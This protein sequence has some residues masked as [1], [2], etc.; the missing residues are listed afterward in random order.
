MIIFGLNRFTPRAA[1]NHSK[2]TPRFTTSF[3]S[4]R[5]DKK[6]ESWR[7]TFVK[8]H[9]PSIGNFSMQWEGG[10]VFF[11][12]SLFPLIF[13]NAPLRVFLFPIFS[14]LLQIWREKMGIGIEKRILFG[15][16]EGVCVIFP[17]S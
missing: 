6:L 5:P 9:T 11:F 8:C 2:H 15:G 10:D 17:V 12:Y 7:G 14:L 1:S 16:G 4:F 13:P 3:L